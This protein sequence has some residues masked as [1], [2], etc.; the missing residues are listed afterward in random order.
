VNSYEFVCIQVDRI[1]P[2]KHP[3]IDINHNLRSTQYDKV[4]IICLSILSV[5]QLISSE[6]PFL[7]APE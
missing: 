1:A 5:T 6:K 3:T 7:Q 4:S 2:C